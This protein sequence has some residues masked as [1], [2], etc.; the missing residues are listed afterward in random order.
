M[1]YKSSKPSGF[2]F[3]LHEFEDVADPDWALDISD[4]VTLVGFLSGDQDDLDLGDTSSGSGSAEQ[5]GDS[6]LDGFCFHVV[7]IIFN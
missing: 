5:L 3:A 6:S 2:S 1:I 4:E 7:I